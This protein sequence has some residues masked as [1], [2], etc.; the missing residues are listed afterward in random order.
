MQFAAP[1]DFLFR[2]AD[3]LFCSFATFILPLHFYGKSRQLT[4]LTVLVSLLAALIFI[5][6]YFKPEPITLSLIVAVLV[7]YGAVLFVWVSDAL[8]GRIGRY[9]TDQRG[10]KWTKEMDYVYLAIGI[11]GVLIS[12]NRIEFVTG[13]FE[14]SDILAPLFLVTAVVIRLIK[15]RAE[16]GGWNR[17]QR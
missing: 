8:L 16:I 12:V 15:T 2:N 5:A 7:L 4:P 1:P 17:P 13:R 14:R 11:V 9:L 10:E 6:L 3:L